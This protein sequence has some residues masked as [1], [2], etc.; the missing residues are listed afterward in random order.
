MKKAWVY[1]LLC[2]NNRFYTGV[3]TDLEKRIA[4]HKTGELQGYTSRFLPV[5]LVFSQ[6]FENIEEAIRAEKKIKGWSHSKKEAL[7]KK[8]YT[9]LHQLS[10]CRNKSHS[11]YHKTE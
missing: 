5:G 8:D 9:Q 4:Q 6:E 3:T 1:I 7:I 11:K 10:N 2:S